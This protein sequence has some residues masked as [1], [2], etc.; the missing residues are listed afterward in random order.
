[1]GGQLAEATCSSAM[2]YGQDVVVKDVIAFFVTR[3]APSP[4]AEMSRAGLRT[5]HAKSMD[6]VAKG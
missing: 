4:T 2:P 6:V 1:M 5:L 3:G